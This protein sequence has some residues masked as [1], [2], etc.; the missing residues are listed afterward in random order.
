M[1]PDIKRTTVPGGLTQ[2]LESRAYRYTSPEALYACFCLFAD[3]FCGVFGDGANAA[4]EWFVWRRNTGALE[5]SDC[6]YGCVSVALRDV[7]L[8]MEPITARSR[9]EERQNRNLAS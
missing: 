3:T 2:R 8:K 5:T 1:Q 4:Y 9:I 6:G 7:L